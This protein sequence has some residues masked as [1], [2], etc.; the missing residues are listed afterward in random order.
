MLFVLCR[1]GVVKKE[2]ICGDL[3][4]KELICG[5]LEKS[6][7]DVGMDLDKELID[8]V[9]DVGIDLEKGDVDNINNSTANNKI[10]NASPNNKDNASPNNKIFNPTTKNSIPTTKNYIHIPITNTTVSLKK[11][12]FKDILI[13]NIPYKTY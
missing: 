9:N 1:E 7:N 2:L 11:S 8:G 10:S 4:K 12:Y 5:D 13:R 6:V 3:E